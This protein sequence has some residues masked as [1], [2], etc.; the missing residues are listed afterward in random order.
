MLADDETVYAYV[1]IFLYYYIF[2][3]STGKVIM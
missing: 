3:I 1:D 2:Y